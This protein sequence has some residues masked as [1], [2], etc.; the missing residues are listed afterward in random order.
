MSDTA[1]KSRAEASARFVRVA[2]P[3]TA[4]EALRAVGA[5]VDLPPPGRCVDLSAAGESLPV[6]DTAPTPGLVVE[7]MDMGPVSLEA[8]GS[9]TRLVPRLLPDVTDVVSGVVYAHTTETNLL[10]A[11]STYVVHVGGRSDVWGFDAQ[12][13]APADPVDVTVSGEDAPGAL[14]VRGPMVQLTWPAAG[15]RDTVFVD[16]QPGSLRCTL[17]GGV[18]RLAAA[19]PRENAPPALAHLPA[20]LLGDGGTLAIH[21]LRTETSS[22]PGLDGVEV[23]F[24][25]ARSIAYVRP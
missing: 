5:T 2:A 18:G 11:A 25:F 13:D 17:D 7:L 4:Q 10:P 22:A 24:D 15:A 3:I 16:V 23:R 14:V 12:A 8:A 20:S 1:G 21:R 6:A 19:A 9:E